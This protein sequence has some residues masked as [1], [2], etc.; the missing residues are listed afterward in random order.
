MS[1]SLPTMVSTGST[2]RPELSLPSTACNQKLDKK[3]VARLVLNDCLRLIIFR[4]RMQQYNI[5]FTAR[6][7]KTGM[8]FKE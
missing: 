8:R 6:H 3:H 2:Q 1:H 5:N 4:I 7:T